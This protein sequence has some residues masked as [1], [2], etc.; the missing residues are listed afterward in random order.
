M[1]NKYASYIRFNYRFIP[2]VWIRL[3]R[4]L[5]SKAMMSSLCID[6]QLGK[7]KRTNIKES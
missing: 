2:D 3:P 4:W 6:T 1:T 7:Q 5:V